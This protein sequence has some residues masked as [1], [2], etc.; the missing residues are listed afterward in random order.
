MI[1]IASNSPHPRSCPA[2]L[3]T[4]LVSA[5]LLWWPHH[6]GRLSRVA[7]A[8][9]IWEAYTQMQDFL[10]LRTHFHLGF[11]VLETLKQPAATRARKGSMEQSVHR[12]LSQSVFWLD[13]RVNSAVGERVGLDLL[14]RP[15][16][17]VVIDSYIDATTASHQ[18]RASA[19]ARAAA[20]SGSLTSGVLRY[21]LTF[22]R[23]LR[24][25]MFMSVSTSSF[26]SAFQPA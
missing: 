16:R 24:P 22:G 23:L 1:R 18:P 20:P 17:P 10:H 19:S 2:L 7:L 14:R 4:G 6:K 8:C 15:R 13:R 11:R 3:R 21:S 25:S 5:F 26:L 12:P 9:K